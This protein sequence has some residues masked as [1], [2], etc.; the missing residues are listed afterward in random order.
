MKI[1][2]IEKDIP[3]PENLSSHSWS[4]MEAGDSVLITPEGNQEASKLY[5][6]VRAQ[7]SKWGKS[8]D[9]KFKTSKMEGGIRI[10]RTE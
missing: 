5:A 8:N 9:A 3:V 10:W 2:K 1:G 4:K 7:A 6:N